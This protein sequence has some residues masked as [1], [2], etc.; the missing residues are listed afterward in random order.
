[1]FNFLFFMDEW[2]SVFLPYLLIVA[3]VYTTVGKRLPRHDTC[4]YTT[5]FYPRSSFPRS[6]ALEIINNV[7][8]LQE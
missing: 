5:P 4:H 7:G 3:E 2:R 1:M 6:D 8:V